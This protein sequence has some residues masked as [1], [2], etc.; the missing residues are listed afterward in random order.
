MR[1]RLILTVC[2]LC[3]FLVAAVLVLR[4]PF[5][6]FGIGATVDIYPE[7]LNLKS[8]GTFVTAYIELPEGYD[9]SDID[10]T[11]VFLDGA[12]PAESEPWA[13]G[14]CDNDDVSDIMVKFDRQTV[15]DYI[16]AKL[17]HMGIEPSSFPKEGV[18]V[19]LTITGLL[20]TETFE[21]SDT[22][23]VIYQG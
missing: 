10:V 21:G 15:I 8:S 5:A 19:G 11:T 2:M 18:E 16:W 12:I 7:T 4:A 23:R 22:I 3:L 1:K 6:T 14:D 20:N 9:V 13:I 17:Y